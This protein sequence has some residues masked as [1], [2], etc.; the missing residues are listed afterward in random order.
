M[1]IG[2]DGTVNSSP[3]KHNPLFYPNRYGSCSFNRIHYNA[4]K[5]EKAIMNIDEIMAQLSD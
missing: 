3:N 4:L 5:K 1:S 2:N